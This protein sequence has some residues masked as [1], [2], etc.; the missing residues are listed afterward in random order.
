[1]DCVVLHRTLV[2]FGPLQVWR[3]VSRVCPRVRGVVVTGESRRQ[4]H[5]RQLLEVRMAPGCQAD[6]RVASRL[7]VERLDHA[8]QLIDDTTGW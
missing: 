6:S 4:R 2:G 5:P 8:P 1:M 7:R 3:S